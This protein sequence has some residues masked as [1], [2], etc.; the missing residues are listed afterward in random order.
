M[1]ESDPSVRGPAINLI[2]QY[3][4]QKVLDIG[5]GSG[6][7]GK[8]LKAFN[9]SISVL[10][11][12]IWPAYIKPDHHLAYEHIYIGDAAVF[13]YDSLSGIDLIIAADVIEHFHKADAVALVN[14]LKSVAPKLIITLPITYCPQGEYEGN[15]HETHLHQWTTAEVESDLG[16][17]IVQECG[18]CGLFES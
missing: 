18:I 15:I 8:T 6:F 10:G 3:N 9:P 4:P 17:K 5:V 14:R 11:I 16:M 2:K 7:Y 1:P 13:D 12:E